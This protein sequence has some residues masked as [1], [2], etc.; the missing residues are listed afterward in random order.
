MDD[1]KSEDGESWREI[2]VCARE[3]DFG[4]NEKS[5]EPKKIRAE[6]DLTFREGKERILFCGRS[7]GEGKDEENSVDMKLVAEVKEKTGRL[8]RQTTSGS[9]DEMGGD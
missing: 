9:E 2:W 4:T 1:K 8:A 6:R 7:D 3:K 5:L